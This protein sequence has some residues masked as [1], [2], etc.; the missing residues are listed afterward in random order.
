MIDRGLPEDL[1]LALLD[2]LSPSDSSDLH[3]LQLAND[4]Y[5]FFNAY[6]S[7]FRCLPRLSLHGFYF[8]SS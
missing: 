2:E 3:M 8:T 6:P 7:V 5:D 4:M 1:D